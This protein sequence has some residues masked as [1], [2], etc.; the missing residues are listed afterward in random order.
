MARCTSR[1]TGQGNRAFRDTAGTEQENARQ[2]C[3]GRQRLVPED[4]THAGQAQFAMAAV[5]AGAMTGPCRLA[6]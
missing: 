5:H 4:Q 6:R 1:L 2:V 3:G